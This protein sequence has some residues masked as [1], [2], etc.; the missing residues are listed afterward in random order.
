MRRI[1]QVLR[2][3]T[4]SLYW[5]VANK[6]HLL[7]LM[8]DTVVG[9]ITIPDPPAD[10]RSFLQATARENQAV[11]L[12]HRRVMDFIGRGRRWGRTRYSTLSARWPRWRACSS[13]PP[14]R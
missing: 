3:G 10:W 6:D 11:L 7:D 8:L 13:I 4:M 14:P 5:H 12:R 9:E 1:A 2:S